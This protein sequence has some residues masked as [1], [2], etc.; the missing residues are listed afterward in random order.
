MYLIDAN[1]LIRADADFYPLDRLP[2]FWDWLVACGEAGD[3]AI[4][5]EIYDEIVAYDDDLADWIK[6][7]DVK[8]ALILDEEPDPAQVQDVLLA[9]YMFNDPRFDDGQLQKIGRDAFLVAYAKQEEGRVIVTR[10]VSKPTKEL[11]NRHVPDVCNDCDVEWTT[12]FEMY[13]LLNFSLAGR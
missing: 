8:S 4:P 12:D 10:E 6:K 5:R 13:R 2:Q 7:E 1:V 3:V 11:G 9:G